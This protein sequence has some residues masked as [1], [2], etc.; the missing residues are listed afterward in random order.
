M[1]R[2]SE[3]LPLLSLRSLL[4]VSSTV[5][6][7]S[8]AVGC[9]EPTASVEENKASPPRGYDASINSR[10]LHRFAPISA[11]GF[12]ASANE[13]LTGL[14]HTLFFEPR[15]SKERTTSCASC[16]DLSNGGADVRAIVIA[17]HDSLH[18]RRNAPT[19]LNAAGAFAQ[20][21]DGRAASVEQQALGPILSPNVM[22]MTT[23]AAVV[24]RLESIPGYV[25]LFRDAFPDDAR[26]ITLENVGRAI[27]AYE[28][29]L[30]TPGRWDRFL[31]GDKS[32]LT[33]TEKEGLRT[34]L[35]VGC[36]VC[37]TGPL[38]GGSMFERVGV[39]EP[40]PNQ[41]DTGRM[42]V[43]KS[44]ADRMMFKVPTL[45][46]VAKTGAVFPRLVRRHSPRRRAEDGAASARYRAH[47]PRGS[48]DHG[49]ARRARRRRARGARGDADAASVEEAGGAANRP[50]R[51]AT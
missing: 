35:N 48:R 40:W 18:D 49:V 32:A 3:G 16:H 38:V 29:R 21:W 19:V 34:F 14:G 37:H 46:N 2:R 5:L 8:L 1:A 33:S 43:T 30:S 12:G 13:A 47:R 39:V 7:G 50:R 11:A 24:S 23:A 6:A 31:G 20:A 4:F 9:D 45:R 17:P 28:R 36:M 44:E 25:A 51:N 10:L 22:G 41:S 42:A 26:P 27:G 15:L